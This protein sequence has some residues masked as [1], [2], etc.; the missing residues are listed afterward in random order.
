MEVF[1]VFKN[2]VV[3]GLLSDNGLTCNDQTIRVI[4]DIKA[5]CK[6]YGVYVTYWNDNTVTFMNCYKNTVKVPAKVLKSLDNFKAW[7]IDRIRH[8][9]NSDKKRIFG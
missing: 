3:S 9:F 8:Y 4:N 7:N 5:E 1:V 2:S 6:R